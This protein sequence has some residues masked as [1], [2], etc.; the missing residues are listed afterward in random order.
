MLNVSLIFAVIHQATSAALDN[1]MMVDAPVLDTVLF[2]NDEDMMRAMF[3]E[4][5]RN[6]FMYDITVI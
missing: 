4:P 1:N 5:D 6:E 3:N 2:Q